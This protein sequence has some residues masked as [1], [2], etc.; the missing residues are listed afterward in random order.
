MSTQATPLGEIL[1][2]LLKELPEQDWRVA[3]YLSGTYAT[4]TQLAAD[5]VIPLAATLATLTRL[6]NADVVKHE[7]RPTP[8]GPVDFYTVFS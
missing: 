7:L 1:H 6:E 5:L 8:Y 3:T 2:A 4:P